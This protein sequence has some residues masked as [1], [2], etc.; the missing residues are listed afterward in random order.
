MKTDRIM[1]VRYKHKYQILLF[2]YEL[3]Y[4]NCG[5]LDMYSFFF[6]FILMF[7]VVSS[8]IQIFAHSKLT[9]KQNQEGEFW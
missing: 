2:K 3:G 1:E 4:L 8:E 9:P 7:R 5:T 6:F